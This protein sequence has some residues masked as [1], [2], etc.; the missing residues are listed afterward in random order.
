MGKRKQPTQKVKLSVLARAAPLCEICLQPASFA[1]YTEIG[2]RKVGRFAHIRAVSKGGPR[3]DPDYPATAIDEPENLFWCCTDCHDIVDT[4][5]RWPVAKLLRMLERNRASPTPVGVVII[6]SYIKVSAEDA[7][8][9]T[10]VDAQGKP[11]V[12]TSG[13]RIDVSAKRAGDVTGLKA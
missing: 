9:V 2:G 6:D 3:Y 4:K 1:R 13:T 7:G 5:E 11:A 10:G 8:D 12:L